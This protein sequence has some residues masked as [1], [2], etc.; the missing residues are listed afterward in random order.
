MTKIA[1]I[2]DTHYGVRNDNSNFYDYFAKSLKDFFNT[3][4]EQNINHIIHLGDLYDRRK[5]VNFRTAKACR[6]LFL[7]VIESKNIETHIITGNHDIYWRNDHRVNAL[8]ELVE[9][10]YRHVKIYDEPHLLNI[11][12][13][14]IQLIPWITESNKEES[15]DA[16]RNSKAEII[17]G[18][19]E[20]LGFE[21]FRGSISDHGMDSS[22]F[23]RY[24][25][26]C[27]GH[28][29]RR[30][31]VGNINYL[32]AFAEYTWSD[33]NDER[34]FSVLDTQ[35]REMT[36]YKNENSIFKMMVYDDVKY[37]DMLERINSTDFSKYTGCYVK[38]VCVNKTNPY[39]FD[40]LFDKLY[41]AAPLD[42]SV[43]EDVSVF[44]DNEEDS[45]IDQA[46]D[47]LTILDSYI[48]G[49]TLNVDGDKMKSFMRNIYQ[50]ALQLEHIE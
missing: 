21:M 32:G 47:T 50:E 39:S 17:M 3:I 37:P 16:I 46:Q 42:I 8:R 30:S 6:E 36:F 22:I 31:S 44:K 28:F 48:S 1:I 25:I 24:D 27:S 7:D 2:C 4:E 49:L 38:V 18:H 15:Y 29:H 20:M 43:I 33:F 26:V 10:R 19:F 40:V 5:Y 41:K 9:G 23:N 35:T 13:L 45:E 14:D 34:G 11:N 12:G